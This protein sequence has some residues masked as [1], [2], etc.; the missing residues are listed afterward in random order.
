MS[1][2]GVVEIAAG[3]RTQAKNPICILRCKFSLNFTLKRASNAHIWAPGY[4]S[5]PPIVF[6]TGL[7]QIQMAV[8]CQAYNVIL[9]MLEIG[10]DAASG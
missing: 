1:H 2:A 5:F 7:V 9:A 10:T 6:G 3:S 4:R 8:I